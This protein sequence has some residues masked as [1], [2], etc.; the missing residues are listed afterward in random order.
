MGGLPIQS[1]WQG[2]AERRLRTHGVNVKEYP[3]KT[4]RFKFFMTISHVYWERLIASTERQRLD[5]I[6]LADRLGLTQ[7]T[8]SRWTSGTHPPAADKFFA[9]VLL[10]LKRELKDLDLGGQNDI[11]FHA[12]QRQHERLA[13]DY[14]EPPSCALDRFVFKSVLRAMHVPA[15]NALVPEAAVDKATREKALRAVAAGLNATLRKEYDA[16]V[17]RSLNFAGRCREVLPSE[18]DEWLA[19]WGVPY[20]LFAMGCTRKWGIED[21]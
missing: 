4:F 15:V 16:D 3:S 21:V 13:E 1:E 17:G 2:E 18:I 7:S 11:L 10:V 12:V 5:D 9:V 8:V 6:E 14:Y 20:T 19:C